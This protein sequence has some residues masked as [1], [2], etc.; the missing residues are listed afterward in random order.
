M[1]NWDGKYVDDYIIIRTNS[2]IEDDESFRNGL[3]VV[4]FIDN[5]NIDQKSIT[6]LRSMCLFKT[7]FL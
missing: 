6:Y 5:Y 7:H 4:Y 2:E 3:L 1:R